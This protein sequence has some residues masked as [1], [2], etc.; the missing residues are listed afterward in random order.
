MQICEH[1]KTSFVRTKYEQNCSKTNRRNWSSE[2]SRS[3]WLVD[4]D[5]GFLYDSNALFRNS[6]WPL[7]THKRKIYSY[8]TTHWPDGQ[9]H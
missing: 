1:Q 4:R 5:E 9:L 8:H 2:W 3:V 6:A 7:Q